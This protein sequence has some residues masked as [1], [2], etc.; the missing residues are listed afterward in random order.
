MKILW[1]DDEIEMLK[2][3]IIFLNTKG[4]EVEEATNGHDALDLIRDNHYDVVFLDEH[5]P[6][7]TGLQTLPLIKELDSSLPVVMVTKSEEENVME[8]ALGSKIADYLIKPVRPAQILLCLKKVLDNE[9][10]VSQNVTTRYRESFM[11]ISQEIGDCRDI[12]DWKRLFV[13][14]EQWELQLS[15]S[16]D[17]AMDEILSMQ[18]REA[19]Q[20]FFKFVQNNYH[21]WHDSGIQNFSLNSVNA[22]SKGVFPILDQGKKVFMLVIDNLRFDHWLAL[23]EL[24]L[25]NYSVVKEAVC[26]SILPTA[27]MYARNSLFAGLTPNQIATMYPDCWVGE[28]E[29]GFKNLHEETLLMRQCERYRRKEKVQ[30]I[31]ASNAHTGG[32]VMDHYAKITQADFSVLVINFIDMISHA[33]TDMDMI[34][35]LA[36]DEAAFRSLAKSWFEHSQLK[37]LLEKL[38]S[39]DIHVV[40]TSDHG[41]TRV[42]NPVKIQ[43]ERNTNTNLRY[44]L[45]RNLKYPSKGVFEVGRPNDIGLPHPQVSTKYIFTKPYDYF[46]YKNNYNQFSATYFDTFQHGGIS[47]EEMLIPFV[48]LKPK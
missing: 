43:G 26:C 15:D 39:E 29:D 23:K 44:K 46:V 33:R 9:K 24:I 42:K 28:E 48:V 36:G 12:E 10:L 11:Q 8:E 16:K 25:M 21:D 31:K 3:H 41:T 1:V 32:K 35:E 37:G 13:K 14:L 22:I 20:A 4:Y 45:G 17:D 6:G 19:N 38:A 2:P 47:M 40:I 27:T 5:M 7:I 34:K 18:K 30:F